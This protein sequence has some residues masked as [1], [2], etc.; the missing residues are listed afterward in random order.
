MAVAVDLR[1][2]DAWFD[3]VQGWTPVQAV[4]NEGVPLPANAL[5]VVTLEQVKTIAS[6]CEW[7]EI[8]DMSDTPYAQSGF[9]HPEGISVGWGHPD[10]AFNGKAGT[11]VLFFNAYRF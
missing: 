8:D 9:M 10:D 1:A 2:I 5:P 4:T 7:V 11:G 3:Q 6:K